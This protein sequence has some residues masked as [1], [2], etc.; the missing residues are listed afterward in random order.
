M[1][2][3]VDVSWRIPSGTL[4]NFVERALAATAVVPAAPAALSPGRE[5]PSPW[6]M[7]SGDVSRS[8]TSSSHRRG[9]AV[10]EPEYHAFTSH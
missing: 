9:P 3:C 8:T 10:G 5:R 4:Q 1:S 7:L 2:Q 6:R